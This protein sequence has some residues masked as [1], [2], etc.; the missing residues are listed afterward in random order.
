MT[1]NANG[2][3]CRTTR[4]NAATIASLMKIRYKGII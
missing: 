1:S 4:E 3:M 2:S